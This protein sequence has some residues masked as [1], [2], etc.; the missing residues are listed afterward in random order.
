MHAGSI[1]V[2]LLGLLAIGVFC[3]LIACSGGGGG[4]PAAATPITPGTI[5]LGV[6]PSATEIDAGDTLS[7]TATVSGTSD[8]SVTWKVDG[9]TNGNAS[10][11]IIS[12]SG[13]T[14][15]YTAPETEG[16][17]VL[18]VVSAVDGN[19]SATSAVNVRLRNRTSVS[20]S[21]TAAT[22]KTGANQSF[23]V[24]VSNTSNTDVTWSVDGVAGGNAT[25]GTISGTGSTVIYTAPT[26]A[27]THTLKVASVADP[28]KS[29]TSTITVQAPAAS[30]SVALNPTSAS[31]TTGGTTSF[32]ATVANASNTAVTW[33]VDGVSGGNATAGTV[34]GSG[35]TVTYTAPASAGTH[36]L[37][38]TSAADTTKSASAVLTIQAPAPTVGV[39]LNPTVA[40]LIAGGT[41][42]FTAAVTGSSTT[43]VTWAVDGVVGGNTTTG[44]VTG[45][46]ATVTY[47]AP[48]TAGSHT[49]TATSTADATKSASAAIT[50]Q[51]VPVTVGVALNPASASLLAG[52]TAS[53][54]ATVTGASSA[55]VAWTVDGIAGGNATTGT[56]SGTGSTVTYTA[57]AAAGTH[58]LKATS[59]ADATK[60]ATATITV[61][62]PTPVSVALNPNATTLAAGGTSSF[63]ATVSNATTTTV[64]WTVD[65][66]AGGNATTGTVSGTGATVTYTAP[67]AGGTHV[68][69]ATSTADT[70]KSASATITV[71]APTPV[72]VALTPTATTVASGGT[73]SF[74]ATVSNATNAAVTWKVDGIAGGN[75]T[76]GT[77]S[78]T[79]NTVTYTAPTAAGTHALVATSSADATK[80]AS[81]TITVQAP[82]VGVTLSPTTSS[83]AAGATLAFT[84]TVSGSTAGVTWTVD[85]VAGGN[86]TTGT[87]AG[88]GTTA[89]Y[90]APN[91]A[92][93]HTVVATSSADSTKSASATI[94]VQ[95]PVVT[96]ALSPTTSTLASGATQSFAATVSGSSAGVA[97]AVD[98]ITNGSATVGTLAVNGTAVVYTAPTAAGTHTITATSL[99]DAT[100]KGSAVVTVQAAAIPSGIIVAPNGVQGNAGTV[101]A[102]TTLEGAKALLQS[103]SRASAGTLRV[104]LRGG[105]YPRTSTFS[106]T[107]SD[108]GSSANPVVYQAYPNE[109]PRLVGGVALNVANVKPVDGTDVNWSRLDSSTRSKIYVVDLSAYASNL[110]NLTSRSDSG[111]T[112]N[113]AMEVF[114]NGVPLTLARYPKAVEASSVN[115]ATET[116]IRVTGTLSPDVTGDYAYKGLDS[117]GRPYYQLSKGGN[118][119]SIAA[120]AAGADWRISNRKDLGG[121]GSSTATWGTWDTFAGPVGAFAPLSGASGTAF[122]AP[123]DGSNPVPGFLLIRSTNGTNQLTAPDSRMTR[124]RAAE[125]MYYGLGYYSWSGSHS[126][127]TSLDP[128]TGAMVLA[129]SPTYGL[130]LGQPFFVY[131]LLEELTAP[132]EYFIDRTNAKLYLRPVKDQA[133]TEVL[134]STLQTPLVQ[135]Q[136]C[137]QIT[138]DGITFEGARDRLVYGSSCTSVAFKNCTFRNAGGY[139]ML[140]SGSSNLVDGCDFR[141]LGKGGVW[142]AGGDR[143]SLT[144]SGTVVQNSEFQAF[145]RLFWTYQPAVNIQSF[146]DYTYNNDAIGITVQNNEIHD[147]PHAAILYSGNEN[148]IRYNLIYDATQWTND[149]GVIYTT[150]REWGTQG[151]LIQN[152]LIRNCGSPLGTALSGIYIDGVGSG[153]KI[154]ANILYKVAPLYAIQHNGGRNV[155]TQ[156]NVFSGHWYGVDIS[157][158]GFEFVNNTAGSTWNLLGK[159]Q[160]FN[161]QSGA[162]ATAYPHVALIPNSWSL[163]AGTS[164]LEPGGS[165][166]YGNLQ[167]GGSGDAYRQ[168]N[169]ATSLAA[170]LTWFT[171]VGANLSQADPLFVDPANLDF[172]LQP[173][174]PMYSIPGFPGIDV[175]KIGIQR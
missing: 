107:S 72:S 171:K 104:L 147:S 128:T 65:G 8:T 141:D 124:W 117:L 44:T 59:A 46:G 63:T 155:E 70:T 92:G 18:T 133:P 66:V 150:G 4:S 106:L 80:S 174:S 51:A 121:T 17:H 138:W 75:S 129:S 123:A 172:R 26:A 144:R 84:A 34:S 114:V 137:Q 115:L 101:T 48:G 2:R 15:T 102:P 37:T 97:W 62:A 160:H 87:I 83:V 60:S 14:V 9:I 135:M 140:L 53:F 161:Y 100:K 98:G 108:S 33:A 79:G 149:A 76:T 109:T 118:L 126:A 157:N 45:T 52:S 50:V 20:V 158:V 167:Q 93:T 36:T 47:T 95:A 25:A 69:V 41:T 136:G 156:Y 119:W 43:T 139:G 61:Q 56:I 120:I 32:T 113:Q 162:W 134:I 71:Q 99:T 73:A 91:A 148:T 96:V 55:G 40:S 112:V 11:G 143:M 39:T 24:T 35:T 163:L 21:P 173:S 166:C 94:T 3:S 10:V 31:L 130:R 5:T 67:A 54:T 154:E 169:S 122:L 85:G 132:G 175:S 78:G 105:I 12:G 110:G 64:T 170:P 127:L 58:T 38:A 88:S 90:T 81:A 151:N 103:A 165:A 29:A 131:N 145:G 19:K 164:W 146:T 16:S 27:G 125:A 68:L 116:T 1:Q 89:T 49:L 153:V 159:L 74:T 152:N 86:T 7:L 42:S 30:V 23:T 82:P 168:H 57:P 77:V 6:T 28:T 111:G 22:I 142:V 13:T